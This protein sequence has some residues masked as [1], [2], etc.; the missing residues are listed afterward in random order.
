MV[1]VVII[2]SPFNAWMAGFVASQ[3]L[4]QLP[5]QP[6]AGYSANRGLASNECGT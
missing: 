2:H 6:R 3:D 5:L 1:G 4:F